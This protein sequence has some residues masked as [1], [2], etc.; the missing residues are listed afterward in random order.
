MLSI[1][2]ADSQCQWQVRLR[3]KG[4]I[5]RR[6]IPRDECPRFRATNSREKLVNLY[7]SGDKDRLL[8]QHP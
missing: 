5:A 3:L 1:I 2:V 4:V 6:I 8:S 7:C